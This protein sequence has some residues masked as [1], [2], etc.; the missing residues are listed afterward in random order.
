MTKRSPRLDNVQHCGCRDRRIDSIPA[1]LEHLNAGARC[2]RMTRRN[3]AELRGDH[4]PANNRTRLWKCDDGTA[5]DSGQSNH[6]I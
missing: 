5:K 4:R 3:N 2:Q 6:E 1:T